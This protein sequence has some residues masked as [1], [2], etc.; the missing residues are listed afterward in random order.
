MA[1]A[2]KAKR[3]WRERLRD[4]RGQRRRRALERAKVRHDEGV[5]ADARADVARR[6]PEQMP[7]A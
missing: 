1:E 5:G 6:H 3:G 2:E 7:P 4:R